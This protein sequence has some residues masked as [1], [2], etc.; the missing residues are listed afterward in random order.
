VVVVAVVVAEAAKRVKNK[1]QKLFRFSLKFLHPRGTIFRK[2][3]IASADVSS[4]FA[5]SIGWPEIRRFSCFLFAS[6]SPLLLL[7]F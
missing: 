7:L 2:R 3:N 5:G 1:A 6:H 4:E